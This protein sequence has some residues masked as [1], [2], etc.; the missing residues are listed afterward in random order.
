MNTKELKLGNYIHSY[1]RSGPVLHEVKSISNN[2]IN[3]TPKEHF[4]GVPLSKEVLESIG[5]EVVDYNKHIYEIEA[6]VKSTQNKSHHCITKRNNEDWFEMEFGNDYEN[7]FVKFGNTL[8]E[9]QN[10]CYAI[11]KTELKY[12]PK[13]ELI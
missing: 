2:F 13:I 10:I 5:A 9:L 7:E 12:T 6:F 11:D 3:D 1:L 4:G 8:H